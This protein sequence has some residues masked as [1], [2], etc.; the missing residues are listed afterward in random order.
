MI[1]ILIVI[2][3]VLLLWAIITYN[4]FIRDKNLIR[5]AWSGIDVQLKRRHNLIPNLVTTVEGYSSHERNLLNE[6][7][8][9]RA[10]TVDINDIK[11]KSVA[12]ADLSGMLKN[13]F[14]VVEN[15]P[16][17]KAN[18]NF[19]DLQNQ[20]VEIEDQIQY[21]RRYYNGTVRRYNIRVESFPAN[22]IAGIFNFKQK[23]YFEI[24]LAT[25]RKT[26]EVEL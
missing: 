15:Y 14:A 17:L 16:D 26:P 19:L 5:E 20:L 2:G 10:K 13:L 8:S 11:E 6:I 21:A 22:L 7:T 9:K 23:V 25:E 18:E 4:L 3:A 1:Y 24:T 12:E